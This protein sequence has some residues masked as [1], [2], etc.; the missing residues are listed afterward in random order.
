[1]KSEMESQLLISPDKLANV[2][3]TTGAYWV[4]LTLGLTDEFSGGDLVRFAQDATVAVEGTDQLS[5]FYNRAN[6]VSGV[7]S[8][9]LYAF[10]TLRI[11]RQ[12]VVLTDLS[13]RLRAADMEAVANGSALAIAKLADQE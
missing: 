8:G 4:R 9:A 1:M 11:P 10:R 5:S 6:W 7:T 12:C 3:F 2:Q 13:G